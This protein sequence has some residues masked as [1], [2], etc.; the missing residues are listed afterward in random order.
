[1]SASTHDPFFQRLIGTRPVRWRVGVVLALIA[2]LVTLLL[3]SAAIF[4]IPLVC[5]GSTLIPILVAAHA[6]RFSAREVIS[7]EYQLIRLTSL[8]P[9]NI[10]RS[11]IRA[12]LFRYRFTSMILFAML[13]GVIVQLLVWLPRTIINSDGGPQPDTADLLRQIAWVAWPLFGLPGHLL[14]ASGIGVWLGLRLHK[15]EAASIAA[16]VIM[17]LYLVLMLLTLVTAFGGGYAR[18]L[19]AVDIVPLTLAVLLPYG[20]AWL[21][22]RRTERWI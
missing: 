10:V 12:S 19:G 22:A 9:A 17:T 2:G 6:A 1:M 4:L 5:I 3:S 8:P 14:M 15:Q 11:L 7:E 13:P 16:G 21:A 18:P 20:S